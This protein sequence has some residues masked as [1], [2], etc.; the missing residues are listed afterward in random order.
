MIVAQVVPMVYRDPMVKYMVHKTS[1]A[2]T[3]AVNFI[4]VVLQIE[5]YVSRAIC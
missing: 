2:L 5:Y 4:K 1:D 3:S